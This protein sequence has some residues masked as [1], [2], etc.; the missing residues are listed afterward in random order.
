MRRIFALAATLAASTLTATVIRAQA[1]SPVKGP[2]D[3]ITLSATLLAREEADIYDII[4]DGPG[5]GSPEHRAA[6]D[7]Y[8]ALQAFIRLAVHYKKDG[9]YKVVDNPDTGTEAFVDTKT[10][11]TMLE[12]RDGRLVSYDRSLDAKTFVFNE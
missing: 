12:S 8:C 11:N 6:S 2:P 4:F 7:R 5:K 10:G 9:R 1:P 3:A